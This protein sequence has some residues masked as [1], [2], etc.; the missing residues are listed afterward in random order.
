MHPDTLKPVK[1][2]SFKVGLPILLERI[3]SPAVVQNTSIKEEVQTRNNPTWPTKEMEQI[4]VVLEKDVEALEIPSSIFLGNISSGTT[5][6]SFQ[7]TSSRRLPRNS[8][9]P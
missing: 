6:C 8:A 1:V 2:K 3:K 9:S 4:E 7:P 5:Y